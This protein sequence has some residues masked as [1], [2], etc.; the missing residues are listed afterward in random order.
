MAVET[1][2]ELLGRVPLF[3][4][5]TQEQLAAIVNK[6]K[7]TFFEVGAPIVTEGQ[8][9]ETAY[10]ILSGRAVTTPSEE[11][12]FQ[13]ELLEAGALVAELSMIVETAYGITIVAMER[14]RAL[15]ISRSDL[16]EVMEADPGIAFHFSEKLVERLASLA[17]DL[18]EVDAKF[19]AL[20]ATLDEAI[21]I[22]C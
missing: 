17:F 11:A 6:G 2:A 22:A 12:G 8:A 16:Y 18:R 1:S 19:A 20:E 9:G 7:K 4:G 14:V 13:P 5:L 10:L 21:A 15:A 3:E